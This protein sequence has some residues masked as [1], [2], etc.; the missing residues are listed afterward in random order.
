METAISPKQTLFL[1]RL[2]VEP[3]GIYLKDLNKKPDLSSTERNQ[4]ISAG[5]IEVAKRSPGPKSRAS[6][7]AILTEKGWSWAETHLDAP[8]P[9]QGSA[10]LTV[11][12]LLLK[13]LK[14][15]V[16]AGHLSLAGLLT[17]PTGIP[18]PTG[19][20]APAGTLAP[21]GTPA[22]HVE[23]PESAPGLIADE[24]KRRLYAACAQI[25]GDGVYGQR[26]RLADLRAQLADVP[27]P[28]LDHVLQELE[29][30]QLAVLYPLDDPREIRPEDEEAALPN[31]S[32]ADRHVLYLSRLR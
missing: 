27:R 31:S 26:V 8:L 28:Q 5:L 25:V 30:S 15:Q 22:P 13:R 24:F 16:D 7:F 20:E 23:S 1:W 18:A 32:G 10:G 6:N 9:A 14:P 29:Q 12:G 4:L 11:L 21:T 3:D 19:T 2:L 17:P